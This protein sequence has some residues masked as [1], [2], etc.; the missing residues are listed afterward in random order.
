MVAAGARRTAPGDLPRRR[1]GDRRRRSRH[2]SRLRARLAGAPRDSRLSRVPL[3]A[4]LALGRPAVSR[5]ARI[6][7]R[8][9]SPRP[10]RT[11]PNRWRCGG[12]TRRTTSGTRSRRSRRSNASPAATTSRTRRIDTKVR[13]VLLEALFSSGSDLLLLPVQDVFGWR[14]RINEPA[15]VG[16]HNWSFRLRGRPIASPK[17]PEACERQAALAE[18]AKS[19]HDRRRRGDFGIRDVGFDALNRQPG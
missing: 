9:Q 10:A 15:T 5:S 19:T 7:R 1:R 3:G 18:W 6:T 4:L 11:I 16:E 12:N 8:R 13:D 2:R 14:D 17:C